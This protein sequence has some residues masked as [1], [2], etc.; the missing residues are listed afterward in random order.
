MLS[1]SNI[2]LAETLVGQLH[3]LLESEFELLKTGKVNNLDEL[4]SRKMLL[5]EQLAQV[6]PG[7]SLSGH[8]LPPAWVPFAEKTRACRLLHQRNETLVSRKLDA[9]RGALTALQVSAEG[10]IDETYDR[11]GRLSWGGGRRR[12]PQNAYQDV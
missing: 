8:E 9:V 12:T 2:P 11:K 7:E 5:L 6:A 10:L 3:G 4:Q 1:S